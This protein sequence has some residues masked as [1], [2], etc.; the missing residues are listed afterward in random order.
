MC[1]LA[2][3]LPLCE[4]TQCCVKLV[5]KVTDQKTLHANSAVNKAHHVA[6]PFRSDLVIVA[7][8]LAAEHDAAKLCHVVHGGLQDV[9]ADIVKEYVNA[10]GEQFADASANV[11]GLVVDHRIETTILSQP[12]AFLRSTRYANHTTATQ[13]RHLRRH[14]A[15]RASGA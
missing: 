11:L 4:V 8:N 14:R 5:S 2:A 9:S 15:C 6:G 3:A 7:R 1:Q 13:P 10:I 12:A